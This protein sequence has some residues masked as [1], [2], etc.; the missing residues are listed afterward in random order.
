[1]IPPY[2][3]LMHSLASSDPEWEW[4]ASKDR[5]DLHCLRHLCEDFEE[6]T[7]HERDTAYGDGSGNGSCGPCSA[8]AAAD[9]DD[10]DDEASVARR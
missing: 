10:D 1:M 5:D 6:D 7:L 4:T 2:V 9:D 8:A 3:Y